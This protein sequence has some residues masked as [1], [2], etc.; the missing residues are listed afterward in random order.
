MKRRGFIK[1]SPLVVSIFAGCTGGDTDNFSTNTEGDP[2]TSTPEPTPSPTPTASP[3]PT[4][5]T[6]DGLVNLM[7]EFLL[8]KGIDVDQIF[9][10][11]SNEGDVLLLAYYSNAQ[12]REELA[13]EIGTIVGSFVG[14]VK[15]GL[16]VEGLIG[17]ILDS[18]GTSVG[19]WVCHTDWVWEYNRGEISIEELA[20]KVLLTFEA[21]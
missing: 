7:E 12:T 16:E 3:T 1:S 4:P 21:R 14:V 19:V 6:R 10:E 5:W 18:T 20:T 17:S 13:E 9:I 8:S 2:T 11:E 15:R